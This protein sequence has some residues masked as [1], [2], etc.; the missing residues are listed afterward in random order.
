MRGP[1]S[2]ML[3]KKDSRFKAAVGDAVKNR[4][5]SGELEQLYTKWFLRPIPPRGAVVNVY[6]ERDPA[7]HIRVSQRRSGRS[8]ISD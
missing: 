1:L 7:C 2:I 6:S 5:G 3:R 4:M 8:L